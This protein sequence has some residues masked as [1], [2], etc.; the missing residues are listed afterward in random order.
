MLK[1]SKDGIYTRK[2]NNGAT[3][4]IITYKINGKFHKK[5]LG[6]NKDGWTVN[7]A[8]KERAKRIGD[9]SSP[10]SKAEESV[11]FDEIAQ[12]YLISIS[13]KSDYNNTVGRYENHIKPKLGDREF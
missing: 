8:A 12:E 13:H 7:K 5:T 11:T 4:F 9:G 2:L 3:S 10:L 6:T 1:T